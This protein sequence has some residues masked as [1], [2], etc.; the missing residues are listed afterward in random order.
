MGCHRRCR[1]P[2][3][4]RRPCSLCAGSMSGNT[5]VAGTLSGSYRPIS[6][7]FTASTGC[8]SSWS[9]RTS[10]GCCARSNTATCA[11]R[12]SSRRTGAEIAVHSA[13]V[14][15]AA[16]RLTV[17]RGRRKSGG[18]ARLGAE[19]KKPRPASLVRGQIVQTVSSR[20]RAVLPKL[21][22]GAHGADRHGVTESH[23]PTQAQRLR[24]P[25]TSAARCR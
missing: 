24:A 16:P 25:V 3:R 15:D 21:L 6:G 20:R 10:S 4:G 1:Q 5:I 11:R 2:P 9:C 12:C 19:S 18:S 7:C 14:P 17:G 23:F 13:S 22:I 8:C